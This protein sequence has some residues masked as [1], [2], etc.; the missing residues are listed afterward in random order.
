[1]PFMTPAPSPLLSRGAAAGAKQSTKGKT[2]SL[3]PDLQEQLVRALLAFVDVES[4]LSQGAPEI[5]DRSG[6]RGR[7]TNQYLAGKQGIVQAAGQKPGM[8]AFE[9]MLTGAGIAAAI[10]GAAGVGG[11]RAA[12]P[13][14]LIAGGLMSAPAAAGQRR[15]EEYMANLGRQEQL[16]DTRYGLGMT[17]L[18]RRSS[19]ETQK[20]Q[21]ADR[22]REMAG[23]LLE[24]DRAMQRAQLESETKLAETELESKVKLG[25]LGLKW[26]DQGLKERRL[27]GEEIDRERKVAVEAEKAADE[28]VM[29]PIEN[30]LVDYLLANHADALEAFRDKDGA[31]IL[32]SAEV[33]RDMVRSGKLKRTVKERFSILPDIEGEDTVLLDMIDRWDKAKTVERP[34]FIKEYKR[35]YS[36]S[37]QVLTTEPVTEAEPPGQNA[38]TDPAA[39]RAHADE[40]AREMGE[41][42]DAEDAWTQAQYALKQGKI[43]SQELGQLRQVLM[44]DAWKRQGT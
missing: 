7:L 22:R 14:G 35:R 40:V 25:E 11:S 12:A 4:L 44:V 1:M 37:G 41:F 38:A 32:P 24:S 16:L 26:A 33:L 10:A 34:R 39:A 23:K 8:N 28:Q 3:P 31:I 42:R 6:A 17:E 18:D 27:Q 13:L 36:S 20:M 15:G 21:R 9:K 2:D 5:T 43:T 30:E 29:A 19:E